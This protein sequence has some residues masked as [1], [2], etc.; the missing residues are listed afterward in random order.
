[1]KW[2]FEEEREPA[3]RYFEGTEIGEEGQAG[4]GSKGLWNK[5]LEDERKP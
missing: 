5:G 1:M 4:H 2:Y 3:S